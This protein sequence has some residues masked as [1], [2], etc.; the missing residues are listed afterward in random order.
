MMQEITATDSFDYAFLEMPGKD[1]EALI[2]TIPT[3]W[4]RMSPLSRAVVVEAGR[5]LTENEWLARGSRFSEIGKTVGLI[6]ATRTGSLSTDI[7]FAGTLSDGFLLASPALFGYTL[8]NIPL[9]EAANHYGL[10][11]PV[12]AVFNDQ[13]PLVA[14]IEEAKRWLDAREDLFSMMACTFDSFG[15]QQ[16]GADFIVSFHMVSRKNG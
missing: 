15:G 11:G 12:Y 10:T 1:V 13:D 8:P 4:G 6:G 3:R 9:A 7:D 2:G 16:S 5:I 14:A